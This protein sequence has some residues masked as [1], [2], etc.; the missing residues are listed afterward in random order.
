M[1]LMNMSNEVNPWVYN[2]VKE[3]LRENQEKGRIKLDQHGLWKGGK[4]KGC[5]T[6]S[7][8]IIERIRKA[9]IRTGGAIT[10]QEEGIKRLWA[11]KGWI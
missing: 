7:D 6:N 4:C 11:E 10:W 1:D 3:W 8:L 2:I 9:I 5:T